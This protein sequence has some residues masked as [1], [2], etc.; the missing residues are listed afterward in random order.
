MGAEADQQDAIEWPSGVK[1]AW[2]NMM[3]D[4]RRLEALQTHR[5]NVKNAPQNL[6]VANVCLCLLKVLM[7]SEMDVCSSDRSRFVHEHDLASL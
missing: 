3:G 6:C 5:H 4:W 2:H 1:F 7:R